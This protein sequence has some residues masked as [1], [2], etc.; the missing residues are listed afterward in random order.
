MADAN[1]M[2]LSGDQERVFFFYYLGY[3]IFPAKSHAA[4][5]VAITWD[6]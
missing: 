3:L 5:Y 2:Q 1:V 4:Q 6:C